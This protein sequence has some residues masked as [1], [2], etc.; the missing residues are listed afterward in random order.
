MKTD[1]IIKF[2]KNKTFDD[3]VL[4]PSEINTYEIMNISD[5]S[6]LKEIVKHI[7]KFEALKKT[8]TWPE[9]S[10]RQYIL[11]SMDKLNTFLNDIAEGV[12]R[13]S[14]YRYVK[15]TPEGQ[16]SL[17]LIEILQKVQ[18]VSYPETD[19]ECRCTLCQTVYVCHAHEVRFGIGHYW[20]KKK[21][22]S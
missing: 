12:C 22:P 17:G 1:D 5:M 6:I 18:H 9:D 3:K 7:D 14:K 8:E 15:P 4:I 16:E 20:L 19:Y 13:C 11:G 10:S 21:Q 2:I